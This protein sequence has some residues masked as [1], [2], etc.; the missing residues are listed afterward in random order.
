MM[1]ILDELKMKLHMMIIQL[2][3]YVK[4]DHHYTQMVIH[5]YLAEQAQF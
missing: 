1:A 2:D 3:T 4:L 5:L